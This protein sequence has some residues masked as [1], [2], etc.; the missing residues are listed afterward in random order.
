MPLSRTSVSAW[1][2]GFALSLGAPP[3]W[4]QSGHWQTQ[5]DGVNKAVEAAEASFAK[6]DSEGAKRAVTEAYFRNFED[7]KLEAAIRKYVSAKRAAEIEKQFSTMRKAIAAN[8]AGT[9]KSIS[10]SLRDAI[11]TEARRLD[12][13]KVAPGVFEVNQ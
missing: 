5:A 9:V 10:H 4:A 6:G 8:D 2:I 3:A 11:A 13:A 7:S 1:L 12:E